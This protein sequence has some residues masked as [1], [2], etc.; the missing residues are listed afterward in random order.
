MDQR[1]FDGRITVSLTGFTNR[2][3]QMID[4]EFNGANCPGGVLAHASGCFN[5]IA[6]AE[7][8]GIESSIRAVVW[9]DFVTL[10]ASHTYL[11]AKDRQTGLALARRPEH[12]GKFGLT[13]TPYVGWTL[14]P[15]LTLI[16]KRFSSTNETER[17]APYARLDALLTYRVNDRVD[18]YLRGENLTNARY[19]EVTNFGT[20]GR[21]LYAG[22]KGTW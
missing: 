3:N 18:V 4:F 20:T 5:N 9:Q 6:K 21:A 15:T 19:Q 17:L 12:T 16:S 22:V 11:Q 7:T 13:I 1:F 10:N 8:A 2:I 14:E